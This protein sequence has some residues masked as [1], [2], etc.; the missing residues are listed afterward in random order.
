MQLNLGNTRP[1]NKTNLLQA[2][3]NFREPHHIAAN[4]VRGNSV[5]DRDEE[6]H[7]NEGHA[8]EEHVKG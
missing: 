6:R 5:E 7:G 2:N 1:F 4:P 3:D 8:Q